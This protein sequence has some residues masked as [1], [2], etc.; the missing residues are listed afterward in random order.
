MN[1]A[2]FPMKD[3]D[4]PQEL[5]ELRRAMWG[6]NSLEELQALAKRWFCAVR[7][8][9]GPNAV[10]RD[11]S[12]GDD[13]DTKVVR[14]TGRDDAKPRRNR[15]TIELHI[16]ETERVVNEIENALINSDRGLYRR[17]GLIVATGF[18]KM[19]TWDE[20]IIEVQ[21]IE[22]R[23]N[24][25]LLEDIEAV[26]DLQEIRHPRQ[27]VAANAAD[28]A[29]GAHA[30][31]TDD[32]AAPAEPRQ[33]RQLP[34]HQGE[35]RTHRL[36]GLL[37]R[38]RHPVRPARRPISARVPS[39]PTSPWRKP[40]WRAFSASSRRSTSSARTTRRWRCRSS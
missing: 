38:H 37:C 13:D 25:A 7:A 26:A 24:Y 12:V 20:R 23:S 31:A 14:L 36:T 5:W 10:S 18:D 16:G 27:E 39:G 33:R 3:A 22:E 17:G 34:D 2:R 40:R 29:D 35:R 28:P 9:A 32:P 8:W 4:E 6:A 1:L 15:P 30:Q 21:I 19:Q 11:D